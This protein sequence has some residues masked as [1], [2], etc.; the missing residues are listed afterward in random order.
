MGTKRRAERRDPQGAQENFGGMDV[1]VILVDVFMVRIHGWK[2][3]NM[4][5][6]NTCS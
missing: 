5:T 3:I 2:L 1:F 4:H 6:L